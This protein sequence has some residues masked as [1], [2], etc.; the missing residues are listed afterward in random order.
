MGE[1]EKVGARAAQ[2]EGAGE[3]HLPQGQEGDA[4]RGADPTGI[5]ALR[6]LEQL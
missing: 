4:Q 6:T 3:G 1:T 2:A 5:S